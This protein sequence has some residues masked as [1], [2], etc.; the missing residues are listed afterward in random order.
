MVSLFCYFLPMLLGNQSLITCLISMRE[1]PVF[2]SFFRLVLS[3][4]SPD[5]VS[6]GQSVLFGLL[7]SKGR[8]FLFFFF[9]QVLSLL[10]SQS[11][12][13]CCYLKAELFFFFH[14]VLSL[15]GSQSYLGCCY[16]KAEPF[17]FFFSS[18][19]VSLGEFVHFRLVFI[20]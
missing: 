13:G 9:H 3:P 18:G 5:S 6:L 14:Q 8:T 7:L 17:F 2:L 12:L 20:L 16:L 19:S 15:L 11:Y 1:E 4:C 10:C